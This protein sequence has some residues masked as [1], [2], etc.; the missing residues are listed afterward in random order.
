MT[1]SLWWPFSNMFKQHGPVRKCTCRPGVSNQWLLSASMF[2]IP[3]WISCTAGLMLF[4]L[5]SRLRVGSRG[6]RSLE[7]DRSSGT[8]YFLW[9]SS[10]CLG[11]DRMILT[12]MPV[13][14][15]VLVSLRCRDI[16]TPNTHKSQGCM[17]S[18][19]T[20]VINVHWKL[21]I[22]AAKPASAAIQCEGE[23][24]RLC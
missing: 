18:Q 21:N 1:E 22:S 12:E 13:A 14:V 7:P 4:S 20:A 24:T 3:A 11:W 15:S 2:I 5:S 16:H 9:R 8:D 6:S 17:R 19:V 10:L 23:G